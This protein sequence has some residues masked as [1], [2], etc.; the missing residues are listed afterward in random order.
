MDERVKG[1]DEQLM[2]F[3][4]QIKKTRP[5]PAQDGIKRRALAVRQACPCHVAG[6]QKACPCHHVLK[7]KL[8]LLFDGVPGQMIPIAPAC[9]CPQIMHVKR[10]G[11][12]PACVCP[13]RS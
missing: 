3:K 8:R 2:K 12:K 11:P 5:G 13:P 6:V 9:V 10:T 7:G 1:L 4:E